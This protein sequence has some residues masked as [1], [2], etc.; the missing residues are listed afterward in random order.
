MVGKQAGGK[1]KTQKTR[2]VGDLNEACLGA[3]ERLDEK[4][5]GGGERI[6]ARLQEG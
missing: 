6:T 4:A 5:G 1:E 2:P 3:G